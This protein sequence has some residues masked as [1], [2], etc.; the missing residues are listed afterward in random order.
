MSPTTLVARCVASS[1]YTTLAQPLSRTR[2]S[3]FG[4]SRS[5]NLFH[6]SSAVYSPTR[7]VQNSPTHLTLHTQPMLN[8]ERKSHRNHSGEK[9]SCRNRWNL[10]QHSVVVNVKNSSIESSK[11][12]L[13]IVAY[14]FSH[15]TI[16]V[17]SHTA[18]LLKFSSRAV[19]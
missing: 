15:S 2:C 9:L 12:N 14:E 8:P 7:A 5:P 3:T 13:E 6:K 16:S 4:I 19:K 11:I 1:T 18:G 10:A 17:T